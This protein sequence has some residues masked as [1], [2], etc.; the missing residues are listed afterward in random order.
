MLF[1]MSKRRRKKNRIL[2]REKK[3]K[4]WKISYANNSHDDDDQQK[5][6]RP[7]FISILLHLVVHCVIRFV[8]RFLSPFYRAWRYFVSKS[9]A[10]WVGD[11][12]T[13]T[14]T[15][16]GKKMRFKWTSHLTWWNRRTTV[17]K[18]TSWLLPKCCQI[19]NFFP[20]SLSLSHLLLIFHRCHTDVNC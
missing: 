16:G 6:N 15:K 1:F 18:G 10:L 3:I 2:C 12:T 4:C 13:K 9:K 8:L 7:K 20:L 11:T 19:T 5:K 17:A 14:T